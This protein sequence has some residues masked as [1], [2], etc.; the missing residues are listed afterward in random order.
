[1]RK[2]SLYFVLLFC[3]ALC[4]SAC[5]HSTDPPQKGDL[6]ISM[7][8]APATN[9]NLV[10]SAV[11]VTITKGSFS[12][13]ID[14]TIS[15]TTA[16]GNFSDLE[17]GTYAI[18]V[19]VYDA[20]TLVATGQGTGEVIPGH[21]STVNI[22]LTFLNGGLVINVDWGNQVTSDIRNVL[23][24]GN[25]HTYF[26][27]G[28]DYHVRQLVTTA[29]PQWLTR[30]QSHTMGGYT[31]QDHY[32]DGGAATAINTGTWDLVVLQEQSSRP[33]ED[34]E[35]FYQYAELLDGIITTTGADTGFYMTWAWR[36]NPEM[37]EPITGAYNYI[38]AYLDAMVS[39]CG[40]SFH[41][42]IAAA[43]T[44]NL[45]AP[46]NYHPSLL[47]TYL[48][49]CTFYG[50]IWNESPVGNAYIPAG[51]SPS[52]GSFL[53]NIAWQTILQYNQDKKGTAQKPKAISHALRLITGRD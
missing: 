31:L 7:N 38:G 1:M 6:P 13:T 39:P 27:N 52:C 28:V 12:Q 4:L 16:S 2:I 45:Y 50:A 26:N 40:I 34:P 24:V 33:M 32:T 5:D 18:S 35:L 19:L 23:F 14:L 3:L 20:T 9:Y 30:I 29:H 43:D 17:A 42:A 8:L 11:T 37:Y 25:S 21:V 51:I 49:A 36:N 22:T 48:A 15:G 44:I 10:I 41:N 46:D 53:Q 47:G